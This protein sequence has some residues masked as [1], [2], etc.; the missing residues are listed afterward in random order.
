[1]FLNAD[2]S[3]R[4][5][6]LS[7]LYDDTCSSS[8]WLQE[9]LEADRHRAARHNRSEL[10]ALLSLSSV[11]D[12]GSCG[13]ASSHS[14]AGAA[15]DSS[16]PQPGQA[17]HARNISS[18]GQH[19]GPDLGC[20]HLSSAGRQQHVHS[21]SH[22]VSSPGQQ[23]AQRLATAQQQQQ[24][25]SQLHHDDTP[26]GQPTVQ[27]AGYSPIHAFTRSNQQA[28]AQR[29]RRAGTSAAG[30]PRLPTSGSQQGIQQPPSAQRTS[31]TAAALQQADEDLAG[32]E[33][34]A[35]LVE[36]ATNAEAAAAPNAAAAGVHDH[37]SSS[38]QK[39][40]TERKLVR[41][42]KKLQQDKQRYVPHS[43]IL[44]PVYYNP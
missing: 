36:T 35:D 27:A 23:A 31:S 42:L 41:C 44:L 34:A 7:D 12:A 10:C 29:A 25:Q 18:R 8:S 5:V 6:S 17:A 16:G 14:A 22:H 38:T 1:M 9:C 20:K 19:S 39:D 28:Q 15:E 13:E 43:Y 30:R 24:R 3:N 33:Q 11:S 21:S 4:T 37:K 40:L 32:L 2:G 26:V